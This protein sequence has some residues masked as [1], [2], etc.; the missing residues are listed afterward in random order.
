MLIMIL[1]IYLAIRIFPTRHFGCRCLN[2]SFSTAEHLIVKFRHIHTAKKIPL[3]L[4]LSS[5]SD[6]L[7][8]VFITQH[9]T[10]ASLRNGMWQDNRFILINRAALVQRQQSRYKPWCCH[11]HASQMGK[12]FM[13]EWS[14]CLSPNI[15]LLIQAKRYD[16]DLIRPQNI[17]PIAFW[18]IHVVWSKP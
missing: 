7:C 14:V 16:F 18:L 4:L 5:C 3:C 13:L 1:F 2:K 6:T 12:V 9:K 15:T 11:H 8:V 10:R 17:F